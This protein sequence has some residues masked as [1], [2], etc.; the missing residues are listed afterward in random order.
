MGGQNASEIEAAARHTGHRKPSS[1]ATLAEVSRAAEVQ[2]P[3]PGRGRAGDRGREEQPPRSPG[4]PH[5]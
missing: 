1:C 2:A 3:H 4:R 5:V